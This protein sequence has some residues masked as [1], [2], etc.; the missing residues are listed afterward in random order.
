MSEHDAIESSETPSRLF[1]RRCPKRCAFAQALH[2]CVVEK[3]CTELTKFLAF[4]TLTLCFPSSEREFGLRSIFSLYR[5]SISACDDTPDRRK[6]QTMDWRGPELV[7]TGQVP[8]CPIAFVLSKSIAGISLVE[9]PH[10]TISGDL[11]YDRST[12]NGET[13]FIASGYSSLR[14]G[15]LRQ[16]DSVNKEEARLSG[17]LFHCLHHRELGGLEDI[18]GVNHLR[19]SDTNAHGQSFLH[20]EVEESLTFLMV[21][22]LAIPDQLEPS[23]T[24]WTW[25]DDGAGHYRACEGSPPHLID[26]GDKLIALRLKL[27]F[28]IEVWKPMQGS[29]FHDSP[30]PSCFRRG[31]HASVFIGLGS[32]FDGVNNASAEYLIYIIEHNSL[33]WGYRLLGLSEMNI[34]GVI[35]EEKGS[36][37]LF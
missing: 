16:G 34:H 7:Q 27:V 29:P 17:Q 6:I 14:D 13:Q 12:G 37:R 15:T 32:D 23:Q 18:H 11:G 30:D 10:H 33:P 21:Q 22:V 3:R 36:L 1:D 5:R 9:F 28:L 19:S 24:G 20:D 26:S 31:I 4:I 2:Y 8:S 25:Q 35:L